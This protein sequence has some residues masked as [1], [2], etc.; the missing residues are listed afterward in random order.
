MNMKSGS[1]LKIQAVSLLL[2]VTAVLTAGC[3][4]GDEP[5]PDKVDSDKKTEEAMIPLTAENL[6]A[7]AEKLANEFA[8]KGFDTN[9]DSVRRVLLHLNK[10]SFTE[11][12]YYAL[13]DASKYADDPIN[14]FFK[15]VGFHNDD[16]VFYKVQFTRDY[17]G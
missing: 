4:K 15:E 14:S 16:M 9:A 1:R 6:D 7:E 13:F 17:T 3:A 10:D 8:E 12:E 11:D 2:A 5:T